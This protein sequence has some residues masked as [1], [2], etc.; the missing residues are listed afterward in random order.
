MID[1]FS[2]NSRVRLRDAVRF[3]PELLGVKR[4][5]SLGLCQIGN[6][7]VNLEHVKL[8]HTLTGRETLSCGATN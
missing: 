7:C 6:V 1:V 2:V 4:P 8:W 5:S 3:R